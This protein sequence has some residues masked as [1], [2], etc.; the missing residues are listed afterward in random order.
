VSRVSIVK[1]K[2]KALKSPEN[3]YRKKDI[4]Q[5]K[6]DLTLSVLTK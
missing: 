4:L 2:L 5:I 6:E 3:A 1:D